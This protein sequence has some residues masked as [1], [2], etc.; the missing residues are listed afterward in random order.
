MFNGFY[1]NL[2][3]VASVKHDINK[4]IIIG[5][6]FYYDITVPE[7]VFYWQVYAFAFVNFYTR[8]TI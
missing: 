1:F 8:P 5:K 6:L 3:T 7:H 2:N 4:L